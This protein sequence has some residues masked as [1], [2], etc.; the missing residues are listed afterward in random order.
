MSH[1]NLSL[2]HEVMELLVSLVSISFIF[3]FII[4]SLYNNDH[5]IKANKSWSQ[6]CL[7]LTIG[8][9]YCELWLSC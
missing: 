1:F 8:D 3:K 4:L 2:K 6:S 7:G 9:L 5:A